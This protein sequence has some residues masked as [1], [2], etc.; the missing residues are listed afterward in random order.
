MNTLQSI[1]GFLSQLNLEKDEIGAYDPH[2]VVSNKRVA[3]K[4][5][6]YYYAPK[7]YGIGFLTNKDW[8]R[9]QKFR[10]PWKSI[11]LLRS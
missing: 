3:N 7:P 1:K 6:P 4:N 10:I 8:R 11:I 9:S 2:K 5:H